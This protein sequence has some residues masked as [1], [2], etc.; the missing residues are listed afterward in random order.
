MQIASWISKLRRSPARLS[1]LNPSG[2]SPFDPTP[3]QLPQFLP[4]EQPS[5]ADVVRAQKAV[6][7]Y[8]DSWQ[9]NLPQSG[10]AGMDGF[11]RRADVDDFWSE[12]SPPPPL[13]YGSTAAARRGSAE[14][15]PDALA[16]AG[17]SSE[18][19]ED[20]TA[21]LF[22][23]SADDAARLAAARRPVQR[24]RAAAPLQRDFAAAE[25]ELA[26]CTAAAGD[27]A[28]AL[29][30]A[31]CTAAAAPQD[32]DAAAPAGAAQPAELALGSTSSAES[33][34]ADA[35]A[36]RMAAVLQADGALASAGR[37]P[38]PQPSTASLQ[39]E[40]RQRRRRR[41]QQAQQNGTD[42]PA[43]AEV[44]EADAQA[45]V[46]TLRPAQRSAEGTAADPDSISSV[47]GLEMLQSKSHKKVT[48]GRRKARSA[49]RTPSRQV[50]AKAAASSE[51][52][53]DATDLQHRWQACS[54]LLVPPL[55]VR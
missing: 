52:G 42:L 20:W 22:Q 7:R 39:Q 45:D 35:E 36:G 44:V 10:G 17:D 5:V 4:G 23:A 24:Q 12:A 50:T 37:V 51:P 21:E 31:D 46:A 28:E 34:A 47:E 43:E 6:K 11:M 9:A 8:D 19:E 49:P 15:Q 16:A 14:A 55:R 48:K 33:A 13:S 18:G 53:L 2:A 38:A 1:P 30:D 54:Q 41:Q 26:Q 32:S 29:Q 3:A 40:A 25:A 27:A